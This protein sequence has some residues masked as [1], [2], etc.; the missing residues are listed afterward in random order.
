MKFQSFVYCFLIIFHI[1]CYEFMEE[2]GQLEEH[3]RV[4]HS[5]L[6]IMH[7]CM[8]N[9]TKQLDEKFDKVIERKISH[10]AILLRAN[11]QS[12]EA[13]N[14]VAEVFDLENA[15][16][17]VADGLAEDLPDSEYTVVKYA[18]YCVLKFNGKSY[19][20]Y[21]IRDGELMDLPAGSYKCRG[22]KEKCKGRVGP[23][24]NQR[25][26]VHIRELKAHSC[27]HNNQ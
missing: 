27:G 9:F 3:R 6:K 12:N 1:Q 14:E 11:K 8:T 23:V 20:I 19:K 4:Y 18:T 21:R 24:L 13:A 7:Q 15:D 2:E 26:K 16:A 25:G 5:S 17:F 10:E 22:L